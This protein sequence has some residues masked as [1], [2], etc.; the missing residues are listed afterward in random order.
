MVPCKIEIM[1]AINHSTTFALHL[2][3]NPCVVQIAI[4]R[5]EGKNIAM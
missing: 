3:Q 4:E 1:L 2:W 5:V